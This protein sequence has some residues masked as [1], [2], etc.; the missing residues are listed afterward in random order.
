V[1]AEHRVDTP[2]AQNEPAAH[3]ITEPLIHTFL[4]GHVPHSHPPRGA[5]ALVVFWKPRLQMHWLS[6]EV[7]FAGHVHL[8]GSEIP[9]TE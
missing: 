4:A 6:M 9:A 2:S 5:A 8:E 1:F 7:E 3:T